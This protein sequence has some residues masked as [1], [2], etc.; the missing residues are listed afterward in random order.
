MDDALRPVVLARYSATF[1]F[2]STS[3]TFVPCV[4]AW[5]IP[6]LTDDGKLAARGVDRLGEDTQQLM[7]NRHRRLFAEA[8]QGHDELVA[9]DA[10]GNTFGLDAAV[11]AIGNDPQEVVAPTVAERVVD[12]L[13]AIEIEEQHTDRCSATRR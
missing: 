12:G 2:A 4:G 3:L 6:M 13:E 5:A 11:D 8:R 1:A 7:G 9:A 10:P